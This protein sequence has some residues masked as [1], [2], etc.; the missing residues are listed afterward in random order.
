MKKNKLLSRL[1]FSGSIALASSVVADD[2]VDLKALG[3]E[4]KAAVIAGEMTREEA[5]A[6]YKAAESG[7]MGATTGLTINGYFVGEGKGDDGQY[8]AAIIVPSKGKDKRK[9]PKVTFTGESL[10]SK[11]GDLKNRAVVIRIDDGL[12]RKTSS[13]KG[14]AK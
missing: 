8:K 5:T 6:K 7:G 14:A 10:T 12:T 2:T 11:F 9:W 3:A 13:D 4:L 1:I